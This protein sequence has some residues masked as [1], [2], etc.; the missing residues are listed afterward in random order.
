MAETGSFEDIRD[1]FERR[2]RR[3]VWATV[4]T[5]DG[6]GRPRSRMLHP[7]WDGTTGWIMTGRQTHK[8]KHLQRNPYVSCSYWD[9]DQQQVFAECRAE[10]ADDP[11]TRARIW[12]MFKNEPPPYGYDPAMFWPG[13]PSDPGFGALKLTPWRIELWSLNDMASGREPRVWR[14]A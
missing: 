9:Q 14:P 3:I 11:A 2:V 5:V 4:T 7:M 12:E 10:W 8:A 6:K 1:E 13:G